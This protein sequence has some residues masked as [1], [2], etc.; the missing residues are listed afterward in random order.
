MAR[1]RASSRPLWFTIALK[2]SDQGVDIYNHDFDAMAC[3]GVSFG[4]DSVQ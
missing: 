2:K 4:C 1:P 3:R